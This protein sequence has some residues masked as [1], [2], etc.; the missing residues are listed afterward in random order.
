MH[1]TMGQKLAVI[2]A[3][4]CGAL[5]DG[6]AAVAPIKAFG[7]PVMDGIGPVPYSALTKCLSAGFRAAPQLLEVEFSANVER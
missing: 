1:Q 3:C 2:L 6:E 4:H 5:A 7:P